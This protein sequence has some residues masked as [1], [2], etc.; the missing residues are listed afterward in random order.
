MG[1]RQ[2]SGDRRDPDVEA[3]ARNIA[4]DAKFVPKPYRI[5]ELADYFRA[6]V[7]DSFA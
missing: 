6:L 5:S 2:P 3:T 4:R 7:I 1:P